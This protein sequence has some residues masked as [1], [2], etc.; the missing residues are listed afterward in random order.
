MNC[1]RV[2]VG[3]FYSCSYYQAIVVDILDG[4]E[5]DYEII[6]HRPILYRA[7]QITTHDKLA[8]LEITLNRVQRE[9]RA[10]G[11]FSM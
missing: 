1:D 10:G 6:A 8:I 3:S 9:Q 7:W 2:D 5:V 4:G 11:I